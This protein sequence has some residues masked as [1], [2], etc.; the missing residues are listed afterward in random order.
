MDADTLRA[1]LSAQAAAQEKVLQAVMKEMR[2]MFS[3]MT[4]TSTTAHVTSAE[5]VTNSLS[6][7]LPEFTH[8]SENGCTFDVWYSRCEDIITQDGAT[9]DEAAKARLIVSELDAPAYARFTN[10]ILP[11]KAAEISLAETVKTLQE[12]F[13]HNTS[14]FTRRYAYLKTQCNGESLRDYTGL[15]NR[16]HEMAEF[17]A[18]TA[19]QM[20]CL[21]WIC[22]LAAPEYADI[23]TH[24]LRKL[25]SNP[26]TTLRE[27]SAGIQQLLDIRQDAKLMCSPPSPAA[28]PS[29]INAVEAKKGQNKEPPSPCFRCGGLHWAKECDF[30]DKR[31]HACHRLGLKKGFRKNFNKKR[32]SNLK[33]KRKRANQVVIAASATAGIAPIRR[34]YRT[35]K[36]NGVS[37][38]MRLDTGADVTLLSHKDWIAV[39]RPKLLPPLFKLKSANN[40][41]INVRGYFKCTFAIDGCQGSGTCHVADTTSL[42]GLDWIAQVEPL[43][44]RLIGSIR[45]NAISDSTLATVRSSLTTRLRKEFPAVFAPGL[46]CCTKTK[47]SLKLKPDATP[48]FRK[49]RPVPYAVQPRIS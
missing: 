29:E 36:V 24:A 35:V 46:G 27:L 40:K 12:L 14:V 34:I 6:A 39:G 16:R 44:D 22:G 7:R 10:H 21:V 32:T 28:P 8:D 49:A 42:L 2:G 48:V 38:R 30:I 5:F 33:K 43:F 19:E 20:K 31:C 3:S 9:L 25:E 41:E 13:G 45:Y 37:T 18:I 1:I 4:S 15:V 23:R 47:A 11:R 26:E 17:N